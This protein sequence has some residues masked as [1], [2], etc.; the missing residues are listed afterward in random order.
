MRDLK[1]QNERIKANYDRINL[2]FPKGMK[3]R[4]RKA[5]EQAGLSLN[6]LINKVLKESEEVMEY[7]KRIAEEI[8]SRIRSEDTWNQEDLK[9]LCELADM[10][11]EWEEADGEN[12]ESVA[13]TAAKKLGVEI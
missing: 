4:Y 2:T 12:F 8:A 11:R 1:K 6:A 9:E 13:Y 10:S 3:E 7:K 5:A